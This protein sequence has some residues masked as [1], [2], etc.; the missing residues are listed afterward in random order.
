MSAKLFKK[1][2][3]VII[4]PS[5]KYFKQ[6]TD[7]GTAEIGTIKDIETINK[8]EL[9]VVEFPLL[10]NP[11]SLWAENYSDED[12]EVSFIEV[13]ETLV[14]VDKPIAKKISLGIKRIDGVTR[15]TFE[16]DK[17]IENM[18]ALMPNEKK[19]SSKWAGLEFYY[20]PTIVENLGYQNKL[21]DYN[22]FDDYGSTFYRGGKMNIAWIRTVGGK[23]D[24][25]LTDP[26]SLAEL[27]QL[28]K[29]TMD[30]LKEYFTEYYKDFEIKGELNIEI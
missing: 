2:Q 24:I 25:V 15:F 29:R 4:K 22:L 5:S 26:V 23:G 6:N 20:I 12:L 27:S 13:K 3:K 28:I 30:F 1:G 9:Y 8:K 17:K 10:A 16:V 21:A 7:A 14:K 19:T 18:Y 11:T